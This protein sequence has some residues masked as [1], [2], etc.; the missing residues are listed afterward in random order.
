M[1]EEQRLARGL[2]M[3]RR[4]AASYLKATDTAARR[5]H[6]RLSIAG[7]VMAIQAHDL[8]EDLAK[9]L[10]DLAD[11]L[12]QLDEAWTTPPLLKCPQRPPRGYTPLQQMALMTL[13]IRSD[14]LVRAGQRRKDADAQA[15][16]EN[17]ALA[18]GV[19]VR[20]ERADTLKDLRTRWRWHRWGCAAKGDFAPLEIPASVER[21]SESQRR[22]TRRRR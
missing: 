4:A 18:D 1:T 7:A 17:K 10:Q 13:L 14:E 8:R 20:T 2:G 11:A 5:R 22:A 12:S 21:P 6:L 16:A 9:P 3:M 15:I 19:G